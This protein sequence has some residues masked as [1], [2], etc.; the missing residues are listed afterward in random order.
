MATSVT[1]DND[2]RLAIARGPM[3]VRQVLVIAIATVLVAVDGFEVFSISFASPEIAT[4]WGIAPAELGVVLSMEMFGMG[5]GA[6]LLGSLADHF[7]RRPTALICLALVTCGMWHASMAD[8]VVLLS[9][10]RL[11]TGLGIGG[12]LTTSNAIV[13]ESTNDRYRNLAI[14][15]VIG[16]FPL[17]TAVGGAIASALL[18][19]TGRWQSIF[20]FGAAVSAACM[21]L[22]LWLVPETIPYLCHRQPNRALQRVNAIL[23]R[24]KQA[25]V[26]ALP[27]RDAPARPQLVDL[28]AADMTRVAVPLTFV[29][30]LHMM[31]FYF[32]MKWIPKVVADM[33]HATSDAGFVLVWANVGGVL[34]CIA[35][36]LLTQL[37]TVR[38][39]VIGALVCGSSMV[40]LFGHATENLT[41]LSLAA[42]T[43][44]FFTT[45]AS[46]GLYA[47]FAHAFPTHL[48]ASGTGL[49]IGFG[50]GGAAL[51]PICAGLMFAMGW[52][53]HWVAPVLACG[54]LIA[55]VILART[56]PR[57]AWA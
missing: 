45:G 20:E 9:L 46:A 22:V 44:G 33:G 18:S 54:S 24:Q 47:I 11:Y 51:G 40:Y 26:A 35:L 49:V 17:G 8:T 53:L 25:P 42:T 15:G 19:A 14:A 3:H 2:P 48:R 32:L 57:A 50:R 6:Y 56:S 23:K 1:T 39:L 21:F 29:F 31:T 5:I 38:M 55:A 28:F 12:L 10:I 4:Q 16:G 36:S 34:G 41:Y 30:F 13:A 27:L 37:L 52:P 7:G 43:A